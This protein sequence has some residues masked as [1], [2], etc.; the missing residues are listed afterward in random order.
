MKTFKFIFA[1]AIVAIAFVSCSKN[2][3]FAVY[4]QT[5]IP[6]NINDLFEGK[7]TATNDTVIV[8][9]HGGP[10]G[11]LL[12][13]HIEEP[14]FNNYYR[15]Y[16]KQA[17]HINSTISQNEI[18][19]AQAIVEDRISTDMY[20]NVLQHFVDQGKVVIAL[21]HSFG[22]F[23]LPNVLATKPNIADKYIIMA[24]RL[25]MPDVVWQGFSD[26]NT[27]SFPDGITPVASGDS[28]STGEDLSFTRL[29]AGLGQ[30]RYTEL[31][32]NKDLTNLHY[33]YGELDKPVGKLSTSEVQFLV[34]KNATV[35]EIV[36]GDHG[37]M[38]GGTGIANTIRN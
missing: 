20:Q 17:Q 1:F 8:Y 28:R 9:A 7:G 29:Q 16:V 22:S 18:T 11:S 35:L 12:T 21:S 25:D 31:L 2:D 24:G 4:Q 5:V 27:F 38:F 3:T 30:N 10:V 26:G 19:L 23:I 33:I 6:T 37:S 13:T 15:V 32:A 14:Q 36:G 34:N